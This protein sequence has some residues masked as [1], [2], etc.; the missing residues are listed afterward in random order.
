MQANDVDFSFQEAIFDA[1]LLA[2]HAQFINGNYL[3]GVR[4][5]KPLFMI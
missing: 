5:F 1:D 2:I 3:D 4:V